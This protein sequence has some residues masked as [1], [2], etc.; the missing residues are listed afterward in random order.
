[1]KISIMDDDLLFRLNTLASGRHDEH[2]VATEAEERIR[3]I[4]QENALL[5]QFVQDIADQCGFNGAAARILLNDLH[6]GV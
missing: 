5:L 6:D 1:M 2:S 3:E 4:L